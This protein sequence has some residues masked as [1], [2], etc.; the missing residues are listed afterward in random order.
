MVLVTQLWKVQLKRSV[1]QREWAFQGSR[2]IY[3]LFCLFHWFIYHLITHFSKLCTGSSIQWIRIKTIKSESLPEGGEKVFTKHQKFNTEGLCMTSTGRE[4][5]KIGSILLNAWLLVDMRCAP[6]EKAT[7]F[8]C[9]VLSFFLSSKCVMSMWTLMETEWKQ[10]LKNHCKTNR[11]IFTQIWRG[12]L[13]LRLWKA[14]ARSS[15]ASETMGGFF[16]LPSLYNLFK[17]DSL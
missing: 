9:E 15:W 11:S 17:S 16:R 12:R 13:G 10:F 8:W 6:D 5:H 3:L 4:F 7:G 2:T 14:T 1:F